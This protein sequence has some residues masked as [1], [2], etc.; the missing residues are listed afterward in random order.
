MLAPL[1]AGLSNS[2]SAAILEGLPKAFLR[3][4]TR[5]AANAA[6]KTLNATSAKAQLWIVPVGPDLARGWGKRRSVAEDYLF[7]QR[8][9]PAH[10]AS[11]PT[12]RTSARACRTP[13]GI[14]VI[15]MPRG[16]K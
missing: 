5:E 8:S 3:S 16:S 4:S 11:V 10:S 1:Q 13:T 2:A 6:I 14:C 12:L 15:C 7:D 9:C